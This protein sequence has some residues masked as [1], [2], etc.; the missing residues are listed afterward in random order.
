MVSTK[1]EKEANEFAAGALIPH[2][3]RATLLSLPLDSI[4]VIKFARRVGISPGIVVGQLQHIGRFKPS[5]L[6]GLKRRYTWV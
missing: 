4:E 3:F 5:Q 6:N 2:E 1:Q